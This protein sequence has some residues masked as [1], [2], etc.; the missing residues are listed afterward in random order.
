[1]SIG[2]VLSKHTH[3]QILGWRAWIRKKWNEPS[4]ESYYIMQLN[5]DIKR[6]LAKNPNSIQT[7]HQKITFEW[8]SR[9]TDSLVEDRELTPEEKKAISDESKARWRLRGVGPSSS[10]EQAP[11]AKRRRKK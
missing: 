5:R 4:Q 10:Q 11:H 1:M 6:L 2:E 3:R 8:K 9:R 7:D